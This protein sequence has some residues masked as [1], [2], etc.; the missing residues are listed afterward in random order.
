MRHPE[1]ER[2]RQQYRRACGYCG[3]TEISAGGALTIDHYRP[4]SA[5]GGDDI[6]NLV[7]ACIKCNQYK[8]DFWPTTEDN[9]QQRR[10]LHPQRD[11]VTL[12]LTLDEQTGRLEPRTETGRFH[13][14]LLRL[15]RPQLVKH[16]LS[17]QLQTVLRE[18][19]QLLEQQIFA[20]ERTIEAQERYIA[21]LQAYIERHRSLE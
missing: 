8:H 14:T 4:R 7:Y 20:L 1:F 9:A 21:L 13:I 16:R 17:Q 10:I 5:D 11:T 2:V 3:V 19:Q 6:D 12:H 18:K 15:N